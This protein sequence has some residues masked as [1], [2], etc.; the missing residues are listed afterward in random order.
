[1]TIATF[2]D[3]IARCFTVQ[4][5]I[6]EH[7]RF[8]ESVE[9]YILSINGDFPDIPQDIQK[10]MMLS[11][12]RGSPQTVRIQAFLTNPVYFLNFYGSTFEEALGQ[13]WECVKLREVKND[14][15]SID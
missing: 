13:A 9:E 7:I 4:V 12:E 8:G 5:F 14:G 1:M 3:L 2:N 6:N 15:N 10:S 11:V